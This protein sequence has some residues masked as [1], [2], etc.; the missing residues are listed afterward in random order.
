MTTNFC[1]DPNITLRFARR[2]KNVSVSKTFDAWYTFTT[3][4]ARARHLTKLTVS[5][6]MSGKKLSA[7]RKWCRYVDK[8]L[9]VERM[10]KEKE[11]QNQMIS[12][13][14]EMES[15]IRLRE[16]AYMK[17]EE[18]MN[19]KLHSMKADH[20]S[21]LLKNAKEIESAHAKAEQVMLEENI[22]RANLRGEHDE[23]KKRWELA[24][25][26][27]KVQIYEGRE[28]AKLVECEANGLARAHEDKA[29]ASKRA[30]DEL[31]LR[32]E[33]LNV[34][35]L[36]TA[37]RDMEIN[38]IRVHQQEL[39][40][41]RL[42][43]YK[44]GI[45][46]LDLV[47]VGGGATTS[48]TSAK[49]SP[50]RRNSAKPS[51]SSPRS[52]RTKREDE[53]A[54]LLAKSSRTYYTGKT[55]KNKNFPQSQSQKHHV[56][57]DLGELGL[58]SLDL[59]MFR[60]KPSTPTSSTFSAPKSFNR[61]RRGSASAALS[62]PRQQ[63][64]PPE[65]QE[66]QQKLT[67]DNQ[68]TIEMAKRQIELAAEK[69]HEQ[70]LQDELMNKAQLFDEQEK[71]MEDRLQNI[72]D[73]H[74]QFKV[75]THQE[76]A[77]RKQQREKVTV[78][79]FLR[80]MMFSKNLKYF[81]SWC[82]F[83]FH[84]KKNKQ[85]V[86]KFA[87]R[88]LNSRKIGA[89]AAWNEFAADRKYKK[90]LIALTFNRLLN[91]KTLH[92]FTLWTRFVKS[93]VTRELQMKHEIFES[94]IDS[95]KQNLLEE[96]DS[97]EIS[98]SKQEE[99]TAVKLRVMKE[100]HSQMLARA[101]DEIE[102]SK[103]EQKKSNLEEMIRRAAMKDEMRNTVYE[104]ESQVDVLN[105][106]LVKSEAK[107]SRLAVDSQLLM[108]EADRKQ[109]EAT[110]AHEYHMERMVEVHA[111]RLEV[112]SAE[113]IKT[114]NDAEKE[115]KDLNSQMLEME[116]ENRE[117]IKTMHEENEEKLKV[118]EAE[119]FEKHDLALRSERRRLEAIAEGAKKE[120]E[121]KLAVASHA[122]KRDIAEAR[123][124]FQ[125]AKSG[126]ETSV[127]E[128]R[129]A[130]EA[131]LNVQLALLNTKLKGLEL[132]SIEKIAD[133][134]RAAKQEAREL[135]EQELK[136][137][138][139]EVADKHRNAEVLKAKELNSISERGEMEKK[140]E[141]EKALDQQSKKLAAEG[142]KKIGK[143][144]QR[145]AAEKR[146]DTEVESLKQSLNRLEEEAL[147]HQK[148]RSSI[149]EKLAISKA[150]VG[151]I[152]MLVERAERE[153]TDALVVLE[154]AR[155]VAGEDEQ[156]RAED[157]V[158]LEQQL[159]S[160]HEDEKTL[161]T[162]AHLKQLQDL[163]NAVQSA[164][165]TEQDALRKLNSME[166]EAHEARSELRRIEEEEKG[167]EEERKEK[168]ARM[169]SSKTFV[170]K[171]EKEREVGL[172]KVK[173]AEA[174]VETVTRGVEA[175]ETL[176]KG[177]VEE[178]N[179]KMDEYLHV[180]QDE[181]EEIINEQEDR[182]I[183]E[184]EYHK[185]LL[186]R[187]KD[188]RGEEVLL[189]QEETLITQMGEIKRDLDLQ[190]VQE[191][192][193]F[194]TS[195]SK[196]NDERGDGKGGGRERERER[197]RPTYVYKFGGSGS[198]EQQQQPKE[199]EKH[200][201]K[202]DVGER[203]IHGLDLHSHKEGNAARGGSVRRGSA[204]GKFSSPLNSPQ[205]PRSKQNLAELEK[206]HR[207]F[208]IGERGIHGLDLHSH[209]Q[210]NAARGGSV[211]RGS[212]SQQQQATTPKSK[213]SHPDPEFDFLDNGDGENP[214]L[215]KKKHHLKFKGGV[216]GLDLHSSSAPKQKRH[217]E[218]KKN[219]ARRSSFTS[220]PSP[221][222]PLQ[223]KSNH[224]PYLH[225]SQ[226]KTAEI[227]MRLK[228]KFESVP[229]KSKER[230][231]FQKKFIQ[232]MAQALGVDPSRIS[233]KG[234]RKGSIIVDFEIAPAP[235][236]DNN[237]N[238]DKSIPEVVADLTSQVNDASSALFAGDVLSTAYSGEV[239]VNFVEGSEPSVVESSTDFGFDSVSDPDE[240]PQQRHQMKFDIGKRGVHGLDLHSHVVK[241][242]RHSELTS[243]TN[244]RR[245]SSI[246]GEMSL[247][248]TRTRILAQ[249]NV[250]DLEF[251]D[252]SSDSDHGRIST[253][254]KKQR[255]KHHLK[256][257]LGKRGVQ[258]LD[259]HSHEQKQKRHS[260]AK[261][262]TKRRKS[263]SGELT[264]S[265]TKSSFNNDVSDDEDSFIQ[266]VDDDLGEGE[267]EEQ[268]HHLK[269][270][271][272][273]K[274]PH[275]SSSATLSVIQKQNAQ[276]VE[277]L[278][279]H[280]LNFNV[281]DL[282]ALDI[283][284]LKTFKPSSI[285]ARGRGRGR[286]ATP[287]LRG[288]PTKKMLKL[289]IAANTPKPTKYFLKFNVG[290]I[291]DHNLRGLDERL[292]NRGS[293]PTRFSVPSSPRRVSS[294]TPKLSSTSKMKTKM[295]SSSNLNSTYSNILF[296]DSHGSGATSPNGI[297]DERINF[298][299][300]RVISAQ[301]QLKSAEVKFNDS[302]NMARARL[303]A[304]R[305]AAEAALHA[306]RVI[307]NQAHKKSM[308]SLQETRTLREREL[309]ALR[310]NH[311]ITKF[312]KLRSSISAKKVL[313][314]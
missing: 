100:Q 235:Q 23:N 215:E 95:L 84:S 98:F 86:Q 39:K 104:W 184:L 173:D 149:S 65:V 82:E 224:P 18:E 141:N 30:N 241:P 282:A 225:S 182:I 209:K 140:L 53:E 33:E 68:V 11:L 226:P 152:H 61:K 207:K 186:I 289:K 181:I 258:G 118:L 201:L 66:Y 255:Q 251:S 160:K 218:M 254:Q 179:Q 161:L 213:A 257:D 286:S 296:G 163:K 145:A 174:H 64:P 247:S 93:H 28:K 219:K 220:S 131:E 244:R 199:K 89:L 136:I 253:N 13:Q 116:N 283:F 210:G 291:A 177:R 188:A 46:G 113:K 229:E 135:H 32:I 34:M 189:V 15:E 228:G 147:F 284:G 196:N 59:H 271:I 92:A 21:S 76:A 172:G 230:E 222:A 142:K 150:E 144:I 108:D 223:N 302:R 307:Q 139:L 159:V 102:N 292:G 106:V 124:H 60:P 294:A 262:S 288:S 151:D 250:A 119:A 166:D 237:N 306:Q 293:S 127:S 5:R 256:F 192:K 175:V 132:S 57:F 52:P 187:D 72:K 22:K 130:S 20:A 2:L 47:G 206:H 300:K 303:L 122:H 280:H 221:R 297:F 245:R 49:T 94:E 112:A 202:F 77:E 117:R 240:H 37:K 295:L 103:A 148:R 31:I 231:T 310:D 248:P 43:S 71:E 176:V 314:S 90:R 14:D 238:D 249:S 48:T 74:E 4:R 10:N 200:Q 269:F 78:E 178:A 19:S 216:H 236:G 169:Q 309:K 6:L 29:R 214:P 194:N 137:A 97:K 170:A 7:F 276:V 183:E 128:A 308:Q 87:K 190:L 165:M 42:N 185:S 212:W 88:M 243:K 69:K 265:P 211:R 55:S 36:E 138:L 285:S 91:G 80:K 278:M 16:I 40:G 242:R 290:N 157:L 259:L 120:L 110:K 24:L 203:G 85:V 273:K 246:T 232:E 272:G 133:A 115:L 26:E 70:I 270:N 197:G 313:V 164:K 167:K 193:D 111:S 155:L 54:T 114:V 38:A 27:V 101:E 25:E 99:E 180:R 311:A 79:R 261:K 62:S 63:Q 168:L 234:L 268:K 281:G 73:D 126:M 12:L 51:L 195:S 301:K 143:L 267:D 153:K 275:F 41:K 305:V 67:S 312:R 35:K 58:S 17:Q 264:I 227:T 204:S 277:K 96:R 154:E 299:M 50:R 266:H 171:I 252:A 123:E 109:R 205:S 239:Q 107:F 3:S 198:E 129:E 260:E 233:I 75:K 9:E 298:A 158:K 45:Y 121:M 44:G 217:S 134:K 83:T 274:G 156:T 105:D 162:S 208:D 125:T 304:Q 8:V 287:A 56:K 146:R 191:I 1:S 263:A 279:K 81:Q